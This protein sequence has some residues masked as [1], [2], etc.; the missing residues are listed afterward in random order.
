MASPSAGLTTEQLTRLYK[1]WDL[2]LKYKK[3][4]L[5]SGIL[6]VGRTRTPYYPH[7]GQELIHFTPWRYHVAVWGR[8]GG[9]T[10][11]AAGEAFEEA[12]FPNKCIWIVAP[13]YTLTDKV[14]REVWKWIVDDELL[15]DVVERA[16]Y[17][18][19][20]QRFIKLKNNTIIEGKS[21]EK[22]KQLLGEGV[23]LVVFDECAE[24]MREHWEQYLE[25]TLVDSKGRALFITT[26]RGHDWVYDLWE[27]GLSREGKLEGWTSSKMPSTNNP[28]LDRDYIE[29]KRRRMDMDTFE[30]EYMASFVSHAGKV[31][32]DFKSDYHPRGHLVS[33]SPDAPRESRITPGE[34]ARWTHY[35]CIDP[36]LNNPTACVWLAVS[37]PDF[38]LG[39]VHFYYEEY[40]QRESTIKDNALNISRISRYPIIDTVFDPDAE[41]R[42]QETMRS[43]RDIYADYGIF[44]R[45]ATND[46]DY[47]HEQVTLGLRRAL[48]DKPDGPKI[49]IADHCRQLIRCIEL[50]EWDKLKSLR[51]VNQPDRPRAYNDHL[52][53]CLRYGEA[54]HLD[55]VPFIDRQAYQLPKQSDKFIRGYGKPSTGLS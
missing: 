14:F 52:P 24:A 42:N 39:Q 45:P 28:F 17:D 26:P 22:P 47:G 19:R 4:W 41:K 10:V 36:G 38:R 34:I 1:D 48:E 5:G 7:V 43:I 20:G 49:L 11:G 16:S 21:C 29:G 23:D 35:R 15:G 37:P 53:S 40:Q 9:K 18:P 44:G 54:S 6:T 13:T 12:T 50:Y 27:E 55:Y 51:P 33:T 3:A 25:P 46:W 30:Q 2:R 31:W 8:R 32:K